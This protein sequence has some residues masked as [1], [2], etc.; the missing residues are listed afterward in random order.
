MQT[1]LGSPGF[2]EAVKTVRQEDLEALPDDARLLFIGESL[3]QL[4]SMVD[5]SK[6]QALRI[7]ALLARVADFAQLLHLRVDK[8]CLAANIALLK[9][10]KPRAFLQALA[11]EGGSAEGFFITPLEDQEK[12]ADAALKTPVP[13]ALFTDFFPFLVDGEAP[14]FTYLE[15]LNQLSLQQK[16]L[17]ILI[18]EAEPGHEET[19]R[20]A[21]EYLQVPIEAV[22]ASGFSLAQRAYNSRRPPVVGPRLL[23]WAQIDE[24]RGYPPEK[25]ALIR[26]AA[27]A[28]QGDIQATLALLEDQPQQ[29]WIAVLQGAAAGK[30]YAALK[31]LLDHARKLPAQAECQ[32]Q[33]ATMYVLLDE[34]DEALTLAA[35][36]RISIRALC[37]WR[38]V[39]WRDNPTEIAEPDYPKLW[40]LFNTAPREGRP[41]ESVTRITFSVQGVS[42]E[43]IAGVVEV[44]AQALPEKR[45]WFLLLVLTRS[46]EL[47]RPLSRQSWEQLLELA[48]VPPIPQGA[49][50][51]EL[52]TLSI[53]AR[54]TG[55]AALEKAAVQRIQSMPLTSNPLTPGEYHGLY[56]WSLYQRLD[57]GTA[58]AGQSRAQACIA[59][60]PA[61]G[62]LEQR[63]TEAESLTD[64]ICCSQRD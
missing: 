44:E 58:E 62:L 22:K 17:F 61:L 27:H 10:L 45:L 3:W 24:Q 50:R 54:A 55:N 57:P 6:L 41:V 46:I 42:Q 2:Q 48:Q 38:Y 40:A 43:S 14:L 19:A 11:H 33:L 30:Q 4:H 20:L 23:H 31:T 64:C 36:F 37:G 8:Y 18:L 9:N 21:R 59:A 15:I 39:H 49:T 25:L 28:S 47:G 26:A 52:A 35:Q 12:S 60:H 29:Q 13:H 16:C 56:M 1:M 32:E 5:V 53:L 34:W 63:M 51:G 7:T